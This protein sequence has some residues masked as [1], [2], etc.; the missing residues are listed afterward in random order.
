MGGVIPQGGIVLYGA[1]SS[2]VGV[3]TMRGRD[4]PAECNII[5]E[6]EQR[7]A[8]ECGS[9][10]FTRL[11][12]EMEEFCSGVYLISVYCKHH[13]LQQIDSSCRLDARGLFRVSKLAWSTWRRWIWKWHQIFH[14]ALRFGFSCVQHLKTLRLHK[15]EQQS[16]WEVSSGRLSIPAWPAPP[17][18]YHF[19]TST[20]PVHHQYATRTPPV[21]N[22]F[23]SWKSS[24]YHI[25]MT[26]NGW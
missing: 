20:P 1:W 3:V 18:H 24:Q 11:R 4:H 23:T 7:A 26:D 8:E 2:R 25:L 21:H 16:L 12:N 13:R 10:N 15:S 17:A 6:L 19:T 9:V 14:P 5:T 22:Q